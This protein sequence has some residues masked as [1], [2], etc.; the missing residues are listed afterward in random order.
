MRAETKLLSYAK[1]YWHLF[2]LAIVIVLVSTY[3][4]IMPPRI[5][6]DAIDS[7]INNQNIPVNDRIAGVIK[8]GILFLIVLILRFFLNYGNI[9][10]TSYLGAKIVYDIRRD[11]FNHVMRLPMSFFDR[12]PSG[13]ITTRIVNDTQNV[14]EFFT[15]VVTSIIKDIFLLGGII[16]SLIQLSKIL[17]IQLSYIFPIVI[18]SMILFRYFDRK[19]YRMVRT[20]LARI[21]AFLAEHIAGV[22]VVKIFN[23]EEQKKK[24]FDNIAKDYY[25]SLI[26]QLYVFGIFRPFMDFLYFLGLSLIIWFGAKYIMNKTIGFGALYAF[27]S[28]LDMFFAPLRDIAEKYDI[29]QNSMASAEKIFNLF[30]ENG[31]KLGKP[32]GKKHVEKGVVEFKNVWFSYD[33]KRWILKDVN[34][35]FAPGYLTAIVGETGAGKTSLMNLLNGLYVPQKGVILVDDIPLQEYDLKSL[36]REIAVVPQD[37]VLFSGTILD[38]IRLFDENIPEEKVLEALEK[39]YAMDIVNKLEKGIHYEV[40]E[41]GTTLSSGER[42]LIVLAR[43]VLFDSKILVLDEATSNIDVETETR[44]QK[45]LRELS[46]DKT[47]IMI[48]HRLS[49]VKDADRIIV[50]H[51]G[52]VVEEGKHRELLKRRGVYYKLYEVQFE[53]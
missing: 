49:T 39:V 12:N 6:K 22:S 5:V 53:I 18:A 24:E 29:V 20:N 40:V 46:K 17:F 45:A 2:V 43:A 36:R 27:A 42:Q 7:Y 47:V 30:K 23:A 9:Y 38:N 52:Q 21:N 41:R 48:A 14:Q 34:I 1:P 11:L 31:E 33:G 44:I 13:R 4:E 32:D 26:K 10:L 37:V 3:V 15:T 35:M 16:I 25:K 28:Y 50:I 19:V 51:N 8:S